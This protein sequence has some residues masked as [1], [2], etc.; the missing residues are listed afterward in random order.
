MYHEILYVVVYIVLLLIGTMIT[1]DGSM[2][3]IIYENEGSVDITLLLDRPSCHPIT[4][5][6]NPQERFP[7]SAT[8]T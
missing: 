7:P 4:I 1:V 5:I 6:A 8:G 2:P 3:Y